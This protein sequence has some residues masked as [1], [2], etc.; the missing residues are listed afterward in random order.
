MIYFSTNC[1]WAYKTFFQ[2]LYIF[3]YNNEISTLL[4]KSKFIFWINQF[5]SNH[6]IFDVLPSL[7]IKRSVLNCHIEIIY[8]NKTTNPDPKDN[9]YRVTF[10][11]KQFYIRWH[12]QEVIKKT[13]SASPSK[14]ISRYYSSKRK[15]SFEEPKVN[16][17]F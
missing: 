11:A 6:V 5:S 7:F 10:T 4:Q 2:W 13:R 17:N 15:S 14:L 9:K 12:Q 8:Q 3:L 16:F 1:L